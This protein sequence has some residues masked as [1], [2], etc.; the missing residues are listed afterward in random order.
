[1]LSLPLDP[2]PGPR[3]SVQ[4]WKDLCEVPAVSA[5][6]DRWFC[7][8]LGFPCRL[9][10]MDEAYRRPVKPQFSQPGDTVSF[11][12]GFPLLLL[13]EA[14]LHDLNQ[15]LGTPVSMRRFR[16]N[17]VVRGGSPFM[18][19]GWHRI[20]V[21]AL[22]FD[23]VKAC[24][25]CVFTTVDPDTAEKD[26]DMQPLRTLGSYRRGREGGVFFGQNL[27]PRT[28][29]LVRLGDPIEVLR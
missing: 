10:Y 3:L 19:D 28:T 27:I 25:R 9:V 22:E 4:V 6:A 17:L 8:Y 2:G 15:R 29:G 11:A 13:S 14:S 20:R 7:E 24:S 16:P 18:E 26:P 21:G 12:D 1:M 5:A 23:V